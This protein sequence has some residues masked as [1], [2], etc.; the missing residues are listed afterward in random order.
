[1]VGYIVAYWCWFVGIGGYCRSGGLIWLKV[2]LVL[3]FECS[4][5][6]FNWWFW[7]SVCLRW[8]FGVF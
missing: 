7:F 8:W 2:G 5:F 4:D 3:V 1:M 6:W